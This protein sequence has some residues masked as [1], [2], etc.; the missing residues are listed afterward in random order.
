MRILTGR[1]VTGEYVRI[2]TRDGRIAAVEAIAS[3]PDVTI[4]PGLIDIQVNGFGGFDVNTADVSPETVAGMVRKL[5]EHGVTAFCPTIISAAEDAIVNA[6]RAIATA[7]RDDPAVARAVLGIH[8]EGPSLSGED[9]YRGMHNAA[10]LRDPDF[11]EFERWQA[12]ADGLIRI[13]T[14]APERYGAVDYIKRVRASDIVVA[15]GHTA[16]T[17]EQISAAAQAGARLSTHLG[18]GTRELLPRHHNAVWPQLAADDLSASFIADGHHL[19]VD[20]LIAM[21]RAKGVQ[22]SILVSDAMPQ[23]GCAP[24]TYSTP[25]GRA[26]TLEPNGRLELTGTPYLAG[27]GAG[28]DDCLAWASRAFPLP[29]VTTMATANPA[30]LLGCADRGHIEIG[31]RAD[32]AILAEENRRWTVRFTIVSGE[33]VFER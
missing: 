31:A 21:V 14:L 8:V 32:F 9:G 33:T 26:V 15:L 12:A 29:D 20:A 27:S 18:N 4:A 28:L 10:V 5:A 13:V 1:L 16:A 24:G 23:A 2:E 6:L 25:D 30:R 17:A 22:R 3:G 7:V 11:A 19:P